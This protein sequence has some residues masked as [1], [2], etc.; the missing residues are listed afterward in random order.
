MGINIKNESQQ[1]INNFNE[2]TSDD[3]NKAMVVIS[4]DVDSGQLLL[5]CAGTGSM[6]LDVQA[7][8]LVQSFS[9]LV[10]NGTLKQPYLAVVELLAELNKNLM[11]A[12]KEA[13]INP[14]SDSKH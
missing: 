7:S 10:R 2:V 5:A 8:A 12:A 1:L 14:H 4:T 3:K 9:Y 13:P 11:D 6:I